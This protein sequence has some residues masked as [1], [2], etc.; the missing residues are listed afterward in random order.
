LRR[1]VG[2]TL[3]RFCI[4]FAFLKIHLIILIVSEGEQP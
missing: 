2:E 3:N 1:L 4:T